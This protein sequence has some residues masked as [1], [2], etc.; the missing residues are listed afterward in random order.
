MCIRDSRGTIST[1]RSLSSP[2]S[3]NSEEAYYAYAQSQSVVEYLINNYGKGKISELLL[4]IRDGY[5]MDDALVKVYG[6]DLKGLDEAWIE[7]MMSQQS[8]KL[9]YNE[10]FTLTIPI[11]VHNTIHLAFNPAMTPISNHS[12]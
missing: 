10:V 4:L 7:Y 2:F 3:A 1:L 11:M 9:I 12:S 8:R 5:T 6:F